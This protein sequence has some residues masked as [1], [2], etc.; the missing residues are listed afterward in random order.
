LDLLRLVLPV[1]ALEA[2]EDVLDAAGTAC[3]RLLRLVSTL[4]TVARMESK[5]AVLEL[6]SIDLEEVI[7]RAVQEQSL[8]LKEE[9]IDIR[10]ELP[11]GLPVILADAMKLE[12]VLINLL[13][14]AVQHSPAGETVVVKVET[15][16]QALLLRVMD[17]GRG[18][19]PSQRQRIF[20]R[21]ARADTGDRRGFGLGL[22]FCRLAVESHGG[23]I[24]VESGPEGRGTSFVFTL[25]LGGQDPAE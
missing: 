7:R 8:L 19:P 3:Q 5:E 6:V 15:R 9:K 17:R 24:W 12:R 21:F 18:I 14:N 22:T 20:D 10:V 1:E 11:K 4:L 25:P 23:R 2:N 13:D 16:A